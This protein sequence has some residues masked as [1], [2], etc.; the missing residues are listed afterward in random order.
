MTASAPDELLQLATQDL[1]VYTAA[2]W[3]GFE[4]AKH[5]EIII[6][7][8]EA[9]RRGEI[10]RLLV[11]TPPRHGKSEIASHYFPGWY[12]G[13]HPDRYVI[14]ASYGQELASDFGRRVRNLVASPVHRAVFPSCRLAEDSSA[15]HRFNLSAGGAYFAVGAGGPVTGRGAHL[16]LIDDPIK[17]R[18]EA[19]SETA[20]RTLRDWFQTVAYTRLM[21]RSA[22]VLIQTRWHEDDLAGWLL[23]E[24]AD[25]GWEIMNLPA[26]A[27]R[28]EGWRREGEALW[29]ERFPL[30]RLEQIKAAIGGVAW[31][32]LYQQRPAAAEG[33]IFRREWWRFFR[34]PPQFRFVVQSWDTAFKAGA[35]NDYSVCATLGVADDGYY[36]VWLW[37]GR[38]EF[39]ELKRQVVSLAAQW[40]PMVVLIEDKA[41]GQ[42]LIQELRRETA[43]PLHAVKVDSDKVARAQG[44]TP[45]IEYGRVHL[46]ESAPWTADLVEELSAFPVGTYD[47]QVDALTQGLNYI[48]RY[49]GIYDSYRQLIA[50]Q[51]QLTKA[52][53]QGRPS[54]NPLVE[55]YLRKAEETQLEH[56][57]QVM[58]KGRT[59]Y[60]SPRG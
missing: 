45:V 20:R 24:H 2:N 40:R 32:A 6:E 53:T 28:G 48:R 19:Y 46:P 34:E 23:R 30:D 54:P 47:D 5:H 38:V 11:L 4:L 49:D 60:R 8:L 27:E 1:A 42:C 9:V 22:V 35:E 55:I 17:N 12:L 41:S 50:R 25:E 10:S 33:Q 52:H 59:F 21:P 29:P 26:I 36:L 58:V 18:E 14:S 51:K 31:A 37:R 56:Q 15:A 13:E 3:P 44:V 57:N 16:L 7:K 39:P 43:I